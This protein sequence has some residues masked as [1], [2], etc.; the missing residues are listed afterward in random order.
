MIQGK[1]HHAESCAKT[2]KS[3]VAQNRIQ[4]KTTADQRRQ[5]TA[6]DVRE[7]NAGRDVWLDDAV[8]IMTSAP[9]RYSTRSR[10]PPFRWLERV[11]NCALRDGIG[12]CDEHPA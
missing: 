6:W 3:S 1:S 11:W 4:G 9:D 2:R 10:S 5:R 8:V 12:N 7:V